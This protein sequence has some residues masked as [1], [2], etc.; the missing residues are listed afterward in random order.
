MASE[1]YDSYGAFKDYAA[2]HLKANE[3]KR[4][5]AQFWRPAGCNPEMSFLELGC[6][7]GL[8]LVYL[9]E[10]GCRDFLGI[11]HDPQLKEW[12][13]ESLADH[14]QQADISEFIANGAG[15]RRFDR[16]AL[17]DVLEHFAPEDGRQLLQGL[18]GLLNPGGRIVI[19]VPNNASPWGQQYQQGD[20][21]HR[22]AY[23][24]GSLRQLA[25][26]AGLECQAC[27]PVVQGSPRRQFTERIVHGFLRWALVAPPE[28]W[29][30]NFVAVLAIRDT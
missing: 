6:G 2:P 22:A 11:D 27:H 13:P 8:F 23:T 25:V 29:T 9:V 24:P 21:T 5:D 1:F 7:T 14:Y 26:A 18:A 10:K 19:R 30:P 15:G 28:I 12:I 3:A 4:F 16:I 20:L 17:F